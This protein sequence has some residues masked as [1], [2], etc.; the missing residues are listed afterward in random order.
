MAVRDP[1][2]CKLAPL[3]NRSDLDRCHVLN[4]YKFPTRVTI[5]VDPESAQASPSSPR[6]G[7]EPNEWRLASNDPRDQG[8]HMFRL[9]T[10]DF[11]FWA[12][13]D[14]KQVTDLFQKYLHH[15]QLD[16]EE[17]DAP[18]EKHEDEVHPV[19]QNLENVAISD[20]EYRNGRTR[21]SRNQPQSETVNVP[22]PPH[23]KE[24]QSPSPV[25]DLSH[26]RSSPPR[27][28]QEQAASFVPLAYNPAAP[29]APEPIAHRE[30]TP[31]PEDG[32]GGTGLSAAAMQDHS[33]TPGAPQSPPYTGAPGPVPNLYGH[34]G[35]P[36]P[37][38]A[39][40]G[41]P[42]PQ[43]MQ[44]QPYRASGSTTSTIPSFAPPPTAAAS[45]AATSTSLPARH[46]SIAEQTYVPHNPQSATGNQPMETP[47]AQFYPTHHASVSHNQPQYAD[48][49]ASRPLQAPIGGYSAYAYDPA[50]PQQ[51]QQRPGDVH[52][53]VYRPT[54]HE[55]AHKHGHRPSSGSG[56]GGP[57]PGKQP[58]NRLDSTTERVEKKANKLWKKIQNF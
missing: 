52:T 22:P 36:P 20:P 7:R 8:K 38:T 47:G 26:D 42:S 24:G 32:V 58:Q 37:N 6:S 45:I 46:P 56:G 50:A 55:Y 54:E 2:S 1:Q 21:N 13:E 27:Q 31:P 3:M 41:S 15:S 19:V 17:L 34:A 16:I 49:L 33:Y 53:Q 30:D 39:G 43:S 14:A 5:V 10:I 40:Y 48:Y 35:S 12:Q 9:H 44:Q 18:E 25:S 51:S 23:Q 11:Y 4:S 28:P 29:A 57:G